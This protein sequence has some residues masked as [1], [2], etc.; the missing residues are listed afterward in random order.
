MWRPS[1]LVSV[2]S[3][4]AICLL[5]AK[6]GEISAREA[7]HLAS[8]YMLCYIAGCGGVEAPIPHRDYWEAPVRFGYAGTHRGS[9]H[10]DRHTSVVSYSW[11]DKSY[12]TVTPRQL[13]DREYE[14]IHRR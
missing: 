12:P 14:L 1:K 7:S 2:I 6:A 9:I 8:T 13:R 10:I 4:L 3:S 11:P 5:S